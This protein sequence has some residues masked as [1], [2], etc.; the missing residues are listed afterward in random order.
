MLAMN[1]WH[2]LNIRIPSYYRYSQYAG[3]HYSNVY[4][5]KLILASGPSVQRQH[6]FLH[7]WEKNY[8]QKNLQD[9]AGQL[10]ELGYGYRHRF[11]RLRAAAKVHW[12]SFTGPKD[13]SDRYQQVI[14]GLKINQTKI[15]KPFYHIKADIFAGLNVKIKKYQGQDADLVS[16]FGQD[17]AQSRQ[18]F[19]QDWRAGFSLS[20]GPWRMKTSVHYQERNSNLDLYDF[21][22]Q[23]FELGLQYDF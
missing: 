15:I 8:A 22:R 7:W 5:S 16:L 12:Q 6:F 21:K 13:S 23:K 17:Y 1:D 20:K 4:G 3:R 11:N 10:I 18:D 2:G 14:L 9:K 19:R